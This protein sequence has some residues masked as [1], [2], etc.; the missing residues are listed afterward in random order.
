MVTELT[1]LP[2]S[3]SL[4]LYPLSHQ[5]ILTASL[6][7]TSYL[8]RLLHALEWVIGPW[9]SC[10]SQWEKALGMER[11]WRIEDPMGRLQHRSGKLQSRICWAWVSA[12]QQA[13]W[14]TSQHLGLSTGPHRVMLEKDSGG[15]FI[16]CREV[17][18]GEGQLRFRS[19]RHPCEDPQTLQKV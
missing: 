16:M 4:F 8:I 7:C 6:Q 15:E 12:C 17:T 9:R 1:I 13:S 2:A 19:F 11:S 3:P 10:R 18:T 14:P 5:C